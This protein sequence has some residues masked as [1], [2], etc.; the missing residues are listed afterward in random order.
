[1][2]TPPRKILTGF[3]FLAVLMALPVLQAEEPTAEQ[4]TFFEQKIRPVL[5]EHCYS[6]MFSKFEGKSHPGS[7]AT[8]YQHIIL[9]LDLSHFHPRAHEG[10]RL[11]LLIRG[12]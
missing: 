12:V 7:A 5:A 8:D 3:Y 4:L 2:K 10:G 9:V 6:I 11:H 1:M